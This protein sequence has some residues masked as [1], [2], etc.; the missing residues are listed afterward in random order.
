MIDFSTRL[1]GIKYSVCGVYSPEPHAEVY[2][3]QL[4]F[5]IS[6]LVY[7]PRLIGQ[8]KS[9]VTPMF[10]Y[11]TFLTYRSCVARSTGKVSRGKFQN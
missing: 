1:G 7:C 3:L 5:K 6:K 2:C 9:R 8:K 11:T 10:S 4:S